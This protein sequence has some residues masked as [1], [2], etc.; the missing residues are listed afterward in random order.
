MMIKKLLTTILLTLIA[1]SNI[2]FAQAVT[3]EVPPPEPD[4]IVIPE[5]EPEPIVVIPEPEP[6]PVVVVPD[7]EP[8]PEPNPEP[9]PV[10]EEPDLDADDIFPQLKN[11]LGTPNIA[12]EFQREDFG[13]TNPIIK[14]SGV[15][16]LN[17][18]SVDP[19]VIIANTLI[20]ILIFLIIGAAS[21]LFNNIIEAHGDDINT[22]YG[23]F[24]LLRIFH[25][26]KSD[27]H[28]GKRK[29]VLF[30]LL[31]AFA[32]VAAHITPDFNI[33]KLENPGIL[34]VTSVAIILG[35]Y[36]KDFLRFIIALRWKSLSYFKPNIMGLFLA[37]FC[38]ILS[39][40]LEISPGYLFGIPMGLY[41]FGSKFEKNEGKLIEGRE[42]E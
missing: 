10:E 27:K 23:K 1:S 34:L 37:I 39:R 5:P 22:F 29:L 7:P 38:V 21:F 30:A 13:Y 36:T 11:L 9:E 41:I 17:Q 3:G 32:F 35:T 20:A 16:H 28:S 2:A 8:E 14:R 26:D 42:N 25:V 40:N 12:D 31:M 18:I 19:L 4:P 33:L 24:R 15:T 6:V